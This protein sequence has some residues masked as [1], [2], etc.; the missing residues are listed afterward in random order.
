MVRNWTSSTN[1]FHR[2]KINSQR[3]LFW[4]F[5]H[6][7]R[8]VFQTMQSRIKQTSGMEKCVSSTVFEAQRFSSRHHYVHTKYVNVF[9][10]RSFKIEQRVCVFVWVFHASTNH[11]DPRVRQTSVTVWTN[12]FSFGGIGSLALT[13]NVGETFIVGDRWFCLD[14]L[15]ESLSVFRGFRRFYWKI[16]EFT[17]HYFSIFCL[18][19]LR[20]NWNFGVSFPHYKFGKKLY[21]CFF[22]FDNKF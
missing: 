14:I 13:G 18:S 16:W 7:M 4:K 12:M 11:C 5:I 9:I 20:L 22:T 15:K 19:I 6:K 21:S 17:F 10:K 1:P 3:L 8:R 2:V